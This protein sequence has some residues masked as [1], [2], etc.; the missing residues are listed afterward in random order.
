MHIVQPGQNLFRIALRYRTTIN[1]IARLNGITNTRLVRAGQRLV[2]VT[3]R[4]GGAEPDIA[5][6]GSGVTYVVRAN[7]TLIRIA[8]RYGTSVEHLMA[9]NRLRSPLIVAGQTLF[10]A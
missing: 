10:I 2:V 7:D 9:I 1:A 4:R 8:L 6:A 5:A 3:C